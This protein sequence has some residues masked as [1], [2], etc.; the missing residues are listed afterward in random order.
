MSN[1]KKLYEEKIVS[2]LT[3]EFNYTSKMQVP[4]LEK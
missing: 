4:R 1:F 2:A 3:K